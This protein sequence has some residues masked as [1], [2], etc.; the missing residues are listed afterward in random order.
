M[1]PME[2][3][4]SS[5]NNNAPGAGALDPTTLPG[6]KV[7]YGK[8]GALD[9]NAL[10]EPDAAPS[11]AHMATD[12]GEPFSLGL[13]W[14][15]AKEKMATS[16]KQSEVGTILQ[17]MQFSNIF[18]GCAMIAVCVLEIVTTQSFWSGV[19]DVFAVFYT[20][21]FSLILIGYELRNEKT[22]AMLRE[23]FGF[24]YDPLG[25]LLFL[26]FIAIFPISMA[27]PYGLVVSLLGFTNAYFN[28]FV[29]TKH[30]SF[31]RGVPDY[32]PPKVNKESKEV[33]ANETNVAAE[34]GNELKVS[35]TMD[36]T[37]AS[38]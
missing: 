5:T 37:T 9:P 17:A 14:E 15:E 1:M 32:V 19:T 11:A 35:G 4:S 36:G 20:I 7:E 28:Y 8:I 31:T 23:N 13:V 10:K 3:A 30:P 6:V 22:D 16:I 27:A 34:S 25:R 2:T 12:R 18:I 21:M 24:M 26:I 38:L 29:I 33:K